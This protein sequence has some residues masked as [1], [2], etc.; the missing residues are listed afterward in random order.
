MEKKSKVVSKRLQK[1]LDKLVNSRRY[2]EAIQVLEPIARKGN[3][4]AQ[5]KMGKLLYYKMI[6]DVET[7]IENYSNFEKAIFWSELSSKPELCKADFSNF[8]KMIDWYEE[9]AAQKHV[10]AMVELAMVCSC[11]LQLVHSKD[12]NQAIIVLYSK[13]RFRPC[14]VFIHGSIRCRR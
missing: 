4:D 14:N 5:Y 12:S 9:A 7:E 6:E 1:Q 3:A 10:K 11:I 13:M 8:N 2:D